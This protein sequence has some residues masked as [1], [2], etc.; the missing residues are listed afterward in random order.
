MPALPGIRMLRVLA[1][2]R[3]SLVLCATVGSVTYVVLKL[4]YYIKYEM[5]RK[6]K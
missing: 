6:A 3:A 1:R 5:N 2:F 4:Y